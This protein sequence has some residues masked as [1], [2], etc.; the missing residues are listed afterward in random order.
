LSLNLVADSTSRHTLKAADLLFA[1][2]VHV[3]VILL[4]IILTWWQSTSKPEPLNRIEVMMISGAELAKLQKQASKPA[5][6]PRKVK[7]KAKPVLK[8]DPK[9][10]KKAPVREIE[11]DFD[12]FAPM[13]SQSDVTTP[14]KT[15]R[16]DMAEIMGKQLS[17]KELDRYIAMMQ[18]AVQ[19]HWKVPAGVDSSIPDPLVEMVLRRN[20]SVANARIVESSGNMAL[21]QTL[22]NAIHAAAPFKIPLQQFEAFRVNK[23]RFRPLK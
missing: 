23:I 20:G 1:A 2:A 22:I 9:P 21:D 16:N 4:I 7:P 15:T 11:D 18:Q 14:K 12:P 3:V 10:V 6:K 5:V 19:R 8:F 17:Q 13:Q